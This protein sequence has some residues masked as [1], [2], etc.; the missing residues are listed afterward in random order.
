M[1]QFPAPSSLLHFV[2]SKVK[3]KTLKVRPKV[4][5]PMDN[6]ITLII[7]VG[8]SHG[9]WTGR[10]N[11]H[12]MKRGSPIRRP[13]LGLHDLTGRKKKPHVGRYHPNIA[14][15]QPAPVAVGIVERQR[16]GASGC[17]Q[18]H[19]IGPDLAWL[20]CRISVPVGQRHVRNVEIAWLL[21]QLVVPP[22]WVTQQ[23]SLYR[24]AGSEHTENTREKRREGKMPC[25]KT[26]LSSKNRTLKH[27]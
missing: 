4:G 7:T 10:R 27:F 16:S 15:W 6:P 17:P 9:E 20:T 26:L 13:D 2:D 22:H 14:A 5:A 12:G 19:I 24:L 18:N 3:N 21:T 8:D 1:G 11:N 23:V 25:H